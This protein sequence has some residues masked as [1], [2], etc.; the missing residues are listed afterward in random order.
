[1]TLGKCPECGHF[2]SSTAKFCVHCGGTTH[3]A[4][5]PSKPKEIQCARCKGTG[6]L[7]A[8]DA[9]SLDN[10]ESDGDIICPLCSGTGKFTVPSV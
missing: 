4:L 8:E 9:P 1:M 10:A 5:L 6:R 7:K 2:M 3:A